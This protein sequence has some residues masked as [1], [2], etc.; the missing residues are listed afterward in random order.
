VRLVVEVTRLDRILPLAATMADAKLQIA[1]DAASIRLRPVAEEG[2]GVLLFTLPS[3]ISAE[4]AENF[5][6]AVRT[7]WESRPPLREMALDFGETN[8]I[9]SSGLGFL[10]RCHRMVG[11]R[12]GSRLRLVNLRENVLNVIKVAKLEGLLLSGER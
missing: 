8:F 1:K 10:I 4:V 12:E 3:R 11:Q 9:D 7:E 6:H 5:G 2:S